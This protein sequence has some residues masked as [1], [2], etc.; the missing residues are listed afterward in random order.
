L[1][2][3]IVELGR[4]TTRFDCRHARHD[5]ELRVV[6]PCH[7]VQLLARGTYFPGYWRCRSRYRFACCSWGIVLVA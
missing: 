3:A 1:V 4:Q 2:G 7:I 5:I 6:C